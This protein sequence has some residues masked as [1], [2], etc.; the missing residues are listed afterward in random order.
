MIELTREQARALLYS[1][2]Y[3]RG[4]EDGSPVAEA[5]AALSAGLG[6]A[7]KP[8]PPSVVDSFLE[9]FTR[10]ISRARREGRDGRPRPKWEWVARAV[11]TI[12]KTVASDPAYVARVDNLGATVRD[13]FDAL[14]LSLHDEETVYVAVVV[15]GMLVE[16]TSNGIRNGAVDRITLEA[17]AAV[18]Q[19]FTAALIPFMPEEARVYG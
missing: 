13:T 17:I 16:L 7:D 6:E 4:A 15:A 5:L 19:S 8:R 11:G 9:G 2:R 12:A 10:G 18:A 3:P 14:G 1:A